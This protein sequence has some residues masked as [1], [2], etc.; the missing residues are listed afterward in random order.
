MPV[1]EAWAEAHPNVAF[2]GFL[3]LLALALA[4]VPGMRKVTDA[5]FGRDR[6]S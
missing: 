6:Q 1:L 5:F 3:I 2:F 4:C